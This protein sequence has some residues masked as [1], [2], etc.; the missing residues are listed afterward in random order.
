M[1]KQ[2]IFGLLFGWA[3][4][5]CAQSTSPNQSSGLGGIFDK[6]LGQ[7]GGL[8]SDEIARGLKEALTVGIKNSSNQ[9]SQLDGYFGNQ[10]LKILF[11]PEVQKAEKTLRQ[12]GLGA[13]CDKFILAL[14][15]GAEDAAG[16]AIPIFVDAITKMTIQDAVGILKG[17]KNAATQYLKRTSTQALTQAFSPVI[18]ESLNKTNATKYYGDLA[19]AYNKIPLVQNKINPDLNAYATQKA[20]DGLFL[21]VEQEEAKI[22]ENP[23]ARVTDLLKKVFGS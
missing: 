22:R 11:P 4:I 18:Q 1:Q 13:E 21:L 10:L 20:I 16:K 7:G 12:I 6:V 15:R 3:F 5:S 19:N 14:N 2:I 17:E 23:A 9:A 8:T